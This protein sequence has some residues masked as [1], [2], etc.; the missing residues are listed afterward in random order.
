MADNQG[1][2]IQWLAR[3]ESYLG[4]PPMVEISGKRPEAGAGKL[5]IYRVRY[6][7]RRAH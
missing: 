3:P 7:L 2:I 5:D 1:E 6:T 4:R